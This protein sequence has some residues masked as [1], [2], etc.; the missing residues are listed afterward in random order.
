MS[1]IGAII[2]LLFSVLAHGESISFEVY[3]VSG[4]TS[5]SLLTKGTRDYTVRDIVVEEHKSGDTR[6]WSKE[7]AVASGFSIGA[8]IFQE[9][10]LTGFGLSLRDR[11]SFM[12]R[13]SLGGFSWD[14]FDRES[15]DIYRK[16]QG[17]GRVRVTL[18][19]S[20][21]FQE[22]ATIEF[23]ED[24]TLRVMSRPWFLYFLFKDDT[25][26]MLIRKGS[27]LRLAP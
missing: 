5:R 1:R 18:V 16:L 23:L 15:G 14:W 24:V 20:Q 12:G 25:H 26:H 13:I 7:L 11:S 3:E 17:S 27:V 4:K 6:W 19:L 22:I 2:L 9:K 8:S 21:P 10:D